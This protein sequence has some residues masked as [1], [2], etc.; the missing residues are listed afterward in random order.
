MKTTI[1]IRLTGDA[2]IILLAVESFKRHSL[3][4][5]TDGTY[6]IYL[7]AYVKKDGITQ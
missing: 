6:R 4:C 5:N 2:Q 1:D 3:F 7:T